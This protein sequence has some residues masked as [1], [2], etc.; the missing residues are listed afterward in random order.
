[1]SRQSNLDF[2]LLLSDIRDPT[3]SYNSF[4]RLDIRD[5]GYRIFRSMVIKPRTRC[6]NKFCNAVFNYM[7]AIQ[8][9][10]LIKINPNATNI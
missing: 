4:I 3:L 10:H 7:S 8:Y 1:M 5:A 2:N 9:G 6:F